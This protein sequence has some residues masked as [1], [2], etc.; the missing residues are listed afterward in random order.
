MRI[1]ASTDAVSAIINV[2]EYVSVLFALNPASVT[3]NHR[4][5]MSKMCPQIV[6]LNFNSTRVLWQTYEC[7]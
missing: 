1:M 7:A 5:Q 2:S 4:E 6:A 3:N